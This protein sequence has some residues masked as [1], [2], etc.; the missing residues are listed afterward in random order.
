MTEYTGE[1]IDVTPTWA[2]LTPA[3]IALVVSGE[4]PES[5][6]TAELELQRMARLADAYVVVVKRAGGVIP[7]DALLA[8]LPVVE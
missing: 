4:T 8:T 1:T 3:L 7:L 5:R 6:Q 2:G